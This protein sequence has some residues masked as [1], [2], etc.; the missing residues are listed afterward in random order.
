MMSNCE[1]IA[2]AAIKGMR[3]MLCPLGGEFLRTTNLNGD[4]LE[5]SSCHLRAGAGT[6][7]SSARLL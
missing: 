6:V 5:S 2:T 7:E 4:G 1:T 3:Q